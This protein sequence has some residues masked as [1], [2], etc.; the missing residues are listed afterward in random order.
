MKIWTDGG[1][2]G[3][4]GEMVIGI[5]FDDEPLYT[6]WIGHGTNNQAEYAAI[7]GALEMAFDKDIE[8][9]IIYSD[10]QLAIKQ[11]NREWRI[12]DSI[13]LE[14]ARKI[15]RNISS[16]NSV[17]FEWIPRAKQIADVSEVIK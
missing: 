2:R 14:Y 15:W 9:V 5:K 11:L 13:L 1:C 7:L 6:E 12:N 4:P 3:N 8:D 10:S 17:V 16:F